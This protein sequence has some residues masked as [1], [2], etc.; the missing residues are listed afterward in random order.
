[1][2]N[3][4][5]G[6]K[7]KTAKIMNI[8]GT[9]FRLKPPVSAG[10]L[11]IKHPG[12][13]LLDAAEVKSYGV[14]ARPLAA[15]DPL[16]PGRLYFLVHLPR[17]PVENNPRRAF[18]GNLRVSAKDRLESLVLSRRAVS[19]LAL[20]HGPA[21]AAAVAEA[22]PTGGMRLRVRLPKAD[23]ARLVEESRDSGEAA[24]RIMELAATVG[25]PPAPSTP[26]SA[27]MEKRTRFMQMP[28]EIIA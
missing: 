21:A 13:S 28:A 20:H 26:V 19:D 25:T 15:G 7:K 27:R 6:R 23:V 12:Q 9:S 22:S 4:L 14:R 2:G 24:R 16:L 18:S 11:L 1:M 8:D 5:G 3:S 17:V 10:E